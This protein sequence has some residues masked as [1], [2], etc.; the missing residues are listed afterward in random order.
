MSAHCDCDAPEP[1]RVET[2]ITH[3]AP[4]G[5]TSVSVECATCWGLIRVVK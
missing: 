1:R 5:T 2:Q 4:E 3:G